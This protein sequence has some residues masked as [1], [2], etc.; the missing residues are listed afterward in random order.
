MGKGVKTTTTNLT[1][2]NKHNQYNNCKSLTYIL[3]LG[4]GRGV[5]G[6]IMDQWQC[7]GRL[8]Q[9]LGLTV[10][11]LCIESFAGLNVKSSKGPEQCLRIHTI[12]ILFEPN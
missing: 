6:S 10:T 3:I 5:A 2:V 8:S 9:R 4:L 11:P 1:Q 12:T 7:T